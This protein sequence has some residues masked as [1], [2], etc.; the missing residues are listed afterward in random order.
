MGRSSS[1][2]GD[3]RAEI[4]RLADSTNWSG[5]RIL[6]SLSRREAFSDRL[7]PNVR[8]VQRLMRPRR[9]QK[10]RGAEW[11]LAD[12]SPEEARVV[13]EALA[14]AIEESDGSIS[15]I[16]RSEAAWIM[17]IKEAVPEMPTRVALRFAREYVS[18]EATAHLDAALAVARRV[19]RG[20]S[21]EPNLDE[22]HIARHVALHVR[23]WMDQPL[24][25]WA[26]SRTAA[27]GYI[28]EIGRHASLSRPGEESWFDNDFLGRLIME[29]RKDE[30]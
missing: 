16:S 26:G 22:A 3:L 11:R 2:D 9:Q 4:I 18:S 27:Q 25:V 7:L 8:T 21:S 13:M 20:P 14:T 23:R 12:A 28:R 17:K 10:A 1:I 6:E 15:D 24:L 5:E 19:V 30:P 29:T